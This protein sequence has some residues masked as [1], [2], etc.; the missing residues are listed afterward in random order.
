LVA[1]IHAVPAHNVIDALNQTGRVAPPDVPDLL[2]ARQGLLAA[3]IWQDDPVL[4]VEL[5]RIDL[6]LAAREIR[7][8]QD[9]KQLLDETIE[10]AQDGLRLA[11]AQARGWLI[12][13]E[14]TF[15]RDGLAAPK[16]V[17]YLTAS[18]RASPYDVWLAPNRA[19][20]AMLLWDR[21]DETT[22]DVAALQIR[23]VVQNWNLETL[24]RIVKQT[25]NPNPARAALAGDPALLQRF[26]ASYFQ[27]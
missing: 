23:L 4:A 22:R 26:E 9:G 10:L 24:I 7:N 3:Q 12:L 5:A 16:L 2:A 25:G 8:G 6:I 13:A 20:L 19:W 1:A 15:A 21:L 18:L 11:P 27:Y 14:A 17:D